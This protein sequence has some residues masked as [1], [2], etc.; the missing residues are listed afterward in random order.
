MV[1]KASQATA[2]WRKNNP[3]QTRKLRTIW[4]HSEGHVRANRKWLRSEKGKKAMRE[5]KRRQYHRRKMEVYA[6]WNFRC[7]RRGFDDVRALQLDHINGGGCAD[8][9][10]QKD[11]LS[12]Y[13]WILRNETE[14]KKKYQLLCANCNWIKR[15]ERKEIGSHG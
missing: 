8:K 6:L 3:E 15:S 1:T 14:G 2:L 5:Q 4:N 13:V 12:E 7:I 9:K 11:K 10:F